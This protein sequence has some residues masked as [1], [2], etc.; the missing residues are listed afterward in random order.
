MT[1]LSPLMLTALLALPALW[2]L[3]RLTPPQPQRLEF[4]PLR[5]LMRARTEETPAQLPWWLVLLR[6]GLAAC[7]ILALAGPVMQPAAGVGDSGPV[8]IALDDGWA[9]APDWAARVE[10]A[11]AAINSAE[12]TRQ[13]VAIFALSTP[14][15]EALS[16]LPPAEAR[17]RLKQMSPVPVLRERTAHLKRLSAFAAQNGGASILWLADGLDSEDARAFAQGLAQLPARATVQIP[18]QTAKAVVGARNA[19]ASLTAT[20]LR[21]DTGTLEDVTLTAWDEKNRRVGEVTARFAAGD[22]TAEARFDLPVELRNDVTRLALSNGLSAGGVQL[23]GSGNRRRTIGVVSGATSD[24]AQ[25]LIAPTYYITRALA[26]TADLRTAQSRAPS[27]AIQKLIGSGVSMLVLADVGTIDAATAQAI[28]EWRAKGG[29]LLRFAGPRLAAS[30]EGDQLLPV[31]LRQGGRTL[32]GALAW[33]TPQAM[34]E[35]T[36][37]SPFA[38]LKPAEDIRINRQVL[39]EPSADLNDRIWATLSDGTPLVTARRDGQGLTI[40]FHISAEASWSSLPLSGLFVDMLTR[41]AQMA[42]H[43]PHTADGDAPD[44][45]APTALALP[46]L[47][48]LDGAG[49]FEAPSAAVRPLPQ[50]PPARATPDH[51][52]GLYGSM[53]AP[54]ALNTLQPDARLSRLDLSGINLRVDYLTADKPFSLTP[55]LLG[56][57]LAAFLLDGL[58]MLALGGA[59]ARALPRKAAAFALGFGLAF[60]AF[61]DAHAQHSADAQAAIDATR[62]TRLA[63]MLTGDAQADAISKG[64]LEGLS[65]ELSARTALE[66]GEPA[67]VNPETDELAFYSL[68]YWPV[69]PNAA[70]LS[71]QALHKIDA[72]M[73]QGGTILFDTRDAGTSVGG[74]SPAGDALKAMLGKLDIPQLQVVPKQHVLTRT[75]YLTE[76]FPGRFSNGQMW[77]EALPDGTDADEGQL[78]RTSDGVSPLMITSNDLAGAWAVNASGQAMLPTDTED[79]EQREMAYRAGI[80]IVMYAFTGNYK[81]DQVHVPALL[82]RLGQ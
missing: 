17:E 35:F 49:R 40:L 82:E 9:A 74:A 41:I 53:D 65:A 32:G 8:A 36:A 57:A 52:P 72:F 70:P 15:G 77:V 46:P 45:N 4:P 14:A 51:P 2:W 75:F 66:P 48:V 43:T 61:P 10:S 64:G 1:F 42:A 55:W 50:T 47:R 23:L 33:S 28:A 58:I 16:A 59:F 24:S 3:M 21:A 44:A 38:G 5:L 69:S 30:E 60:T 26:P 54:V 56:V 39:A 6:L 27:E 73:K 76:G 81:A 7:I 19:A 22:A 78:T 79:Y 13:P 20:V 34:G 12:W 11:N 31:A 68:I 80:N 18:A 29:V 63:Y 67:G 25:P 37:N 71:P 62:E